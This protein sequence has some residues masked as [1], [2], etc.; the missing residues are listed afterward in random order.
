MKKKRILIFT[1]CYD[2]AKNELYVLLDCLLENAEV[3]HYVIDPVVPIPNFSIIDA[4]F[5]IRLMAD[6]YQ[7]GDLFLVVM[8]A[9]PTR[10]ERIFGQT[11]SGIFFVGNNSGYFNWL[12]EDHG[13]SQLYVNKITRDVDGRSFGGKYVQVPTACHILEGK[14]LESIGEFNLCLKNNFIIPDQ[15]LVF[16]DNFGLM[17]IKSSISPEYD[18][19]TPLKFFVNGKERANGIYTKELKKHKPG[20]WVLFKGSSLGGMP[21]IGK[22]RSLN[23]AQELGAKVGDI[24]EWIPERQSI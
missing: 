12:F 18:E 4:A 16:I 3:Q 2:I 11:K 21:E 6:H 15:C 14:P 10:P 20:T 24:L 19:G 1:D 5:M 9:L 22:V 7:E 13:V 8:N 17:K 23:S